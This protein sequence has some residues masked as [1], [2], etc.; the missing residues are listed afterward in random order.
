VFSNES[1]KRAAVSMLAPMPL[2]SSSA[3]GA[4]GAPPT[5]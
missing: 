5:T 2:N 4:S 1:M 3:A